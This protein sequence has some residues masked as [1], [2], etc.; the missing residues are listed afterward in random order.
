MS[1]NLPIQGGV[2][3]PVDCKCYGAVMSA[4]VGLIKAGKPPSVALEAAQ[5]VYCYHHPEDTTANQFLTVERWI[6]ERHLH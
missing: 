3:E 6:N 2:K 5:I 4:Y 1:C